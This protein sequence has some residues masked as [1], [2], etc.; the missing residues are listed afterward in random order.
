MN[1]RSSSV[2]V[3]LIMALLAGL[4]L[5]QPVA[6]Q[7]R[8]QPPSTPV[9]E[10]YFGL[11]VHYPSDTD[12][13]NVHFGA[14]R[15]WDSGTE[16]W[17]IEPHKGQRDWQVLDKIVDVAEQHHVQIM[18][19]LMSTPTWASAR[20]KE[21]PTSRQAGYTAEPRDIN[22]W[23]DF[24]RAVGMRYKGRIQAY[25]IWNEP[26]SN[27]FY[28]GKP[29]TLVAMAKEAYKILHEVDPSVLVV[30]PP[31]A[32]GHVEYLDAYLGAG[33]GEYCDVIGYHFY[34]S[35]DLPETMIGWI[36][37]VKGIMAKH[38]QSGKP[39][40]DT[41]TGYYTQ[42]REREVKPSGPFV[43]TTFDQFAAYVARAYILNWA[44]GA[45]RLYWY[46]WDDA[47]EGLADK[48]GTVRKPAAEA[49]DHVAQWLTGAVMK[50][51][52]SDSTDT[53]ICEITR[54][55]NYGGYIVW[56]TKGT[57]KFAIPSN[58]NARW[59]VDIGAP[60]RSVAGVKET[61]IGIEPILLENLAK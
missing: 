13:P 21:V 38:G 20:P 1:A 35:P 18:L 54:P 47:S 50:S 32:G 16:W 58:W 22:D 3:C 24:V 44:A 39:L 15:L 33:G 26:N 56:N 40:W 49:Y 8:V 57:T 46:G 55:G 11:H 4:L 52:S 10:S 29:E 34:V 51:C 41:E 5:N 19:T 31:I 53:W 2:I 48:Y 23:R 42:S 59:Q 36:E 7:A 6:A 37:K 9:P 14:I 60:G 27:Q 43:V 28:S 30:S 61:E 17:H 25:E 12:W 45:S